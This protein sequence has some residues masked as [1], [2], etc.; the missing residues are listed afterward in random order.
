[1]GHKESHKLS[2]PDNFKR[3]GHSASLVHKHLQTGEKGEP[4]PSHY[5]HSKSKSKRKRRKNPP[6]ERER[7]KGVAEEIIKRRNQERRRV[8]CAR[9]LKSNDADSKDAGKPTVSDAIRS[10]FWQFEFQR[11]FVERGRGDVKVC[12]LYLQG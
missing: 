9:N 4:L 11:D 10:D 12:S 3:R 6:R 7:E 1:M 2:W 8:F 5:H